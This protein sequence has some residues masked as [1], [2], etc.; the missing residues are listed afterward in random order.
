MANEIK[1]QQQQP[2]Q[3]KAGKGLS[4]RFV[5][6]LLVMALVLLMAVLSTMEEGN[7]FAALRRWLM[8]G[9]SGETG[10]SYTYAAD[11]DNQYGM[12]GDRLLV[13]TPNTVRLLSTDGKPVYE[14]SVSMSQPRLSLGGSRAVVCDIGGDTL[15]VLDRT[16]VVETQTLDRGLCYFAA[17]L[18]G[19]DDLA[20]ISQKNG[21]KASV[22]VY[23]KDG[24]L[25]FHFDSHDSYLSDAVVTEDGGQLVIVALGEQSGAFTST[26]VTYDIATAQLAGE[27]V[28]PDGLVMEL[29][30]NDEQRLCLCDK[31]LAIIT[32]AGETLLDRTFGNLHLQGYALTG[33]DFC[34]LLLGRYQSGS[35]GQLTTY[36]L[37]GQEL[38]TL[39]IGE[40]VLDL[41]AAGDY[42][43]VL[44]S[45]SLVIYTRELAE[46][47]RL[48]STDYA[49]QVRMLDDGTALVISGASAWRFQP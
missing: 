41:S 11:A 18:N 3:E 48:D 21:Y 16:G 34:A 28:I 25:R 32:S 49:S 30:V 35:V 19:S 9:S 33:G 20:V 8:Y 24:Q 42:L 40:E 26:L 36:D 1:Q 44:Y 10:E 45:N 39:E 2:Q 46:H 7:Q 15:Y 27:C 6:L 31:R 14:L 17:R 47:V 12:L 23:G 22:A 29:A 13:V 38:A 4:G 43:A 37:Q 5:T